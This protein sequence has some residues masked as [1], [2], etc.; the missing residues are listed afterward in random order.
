MRIEFG[1]IIVTAEKLAYLYTRLLKTLQYLTTCL[2]QLLLI[3]ELE[4]YIRYYVF[5]NCIHD[6]DDSIGNIF[7]DYSSSTG[8]TG[9]VVLLK[10]Y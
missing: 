8:I 1:I 5:Q 9:V 7:N 2:A 10:L 3:N 6:F 4:T